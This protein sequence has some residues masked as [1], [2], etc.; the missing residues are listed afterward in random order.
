[1]WWSLNECI[2]SFTIFFF[3]QMEML[4]FSRIV[5]QW[6]N[7]TRQPG[8]PQRNRVF[9]LIYTHEQLASLFPG[10][11]RRHYVPSWDDHPAAY[12]RISAKTDILPKI[13]I[14]LLLTGAPLSMHNQLRIILMDVTLNELLCIRIILGWL[15]MGSLPFPWVLQI[16]K[17]WT[18]CILKLVQPKPAY[19]K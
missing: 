15:C 3:F 2:G 7:K 8:S 1:M 10:M 6:D 18:R 5:N 16:C 9:S 12:I 13:N 4:R 17:E 14:W 19:Y 11:S